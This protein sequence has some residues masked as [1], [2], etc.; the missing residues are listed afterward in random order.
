VLADPDAAR[1]V[2]ERA[3]RTSGDGLA[4]LRLAGC[5]PTVMRHREGRGARSGTTSTT[6]RIWDSRTGRSASWP[7][8]TARRDGPRTPACRHCG[9]RRCAGAARCGSPSRSPCCPTST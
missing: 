4:D 8:Y 2:L 9:L 5:T 1:S 3:L 6:V 7:S